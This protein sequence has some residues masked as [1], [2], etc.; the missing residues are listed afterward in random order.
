MDTLSPLAKGTAVEIKKVLLVEDNPADAYLVGH[1]FREFGDGE[2]QMTHEPYLRG[3]LNRLSEGRFD[4]VLLDLLLPE[5]SGLSSLFQV[6]LNHPNVPVV[7]LTGLGDGATALQALRWGA[8]DYV[9]K[10]VVAN[11]DTLVRISRFAI[12]RQKHRFHS[13]P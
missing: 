9:L 10:N 12:E 6:M 11:R 2:F 3:A 4:L 7:V 13:R 1:V 5:S 8:Q